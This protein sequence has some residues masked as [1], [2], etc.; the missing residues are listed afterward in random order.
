MV[1]VAN[2][3]VARC[4]TIDANVVDGHVVCVQPPSNGLHQ[5]AHGHLQRRV[6]SAP[7][8]F[9]LTVHHVGQPFHL[10]VSQCPPTYL[11]FR[12]RPAHGSRRSAIG[13]CCF[14]ARAAFERGLRQEF[15]LSSKVDAENE[16]KLRPNQIVWR[17]TGVK[18]GSLR[19]ASY[20]RR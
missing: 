1:I 4:A 18:Y 15:T 12:R 11:Y 14:H 5:L 9:Q 19:T 2:N 17:K 16:R 13:G 6:V 3:D 20:R 8:Y 10:V 7:W